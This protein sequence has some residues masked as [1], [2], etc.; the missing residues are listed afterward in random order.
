MAGA[1]V[2]AT[3]AMARLRRVFIFG[4]PVGLGGDGPLLISVAIRN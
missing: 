4:L 3:A 1:A 2:K